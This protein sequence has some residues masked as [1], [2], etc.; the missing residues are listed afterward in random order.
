MERTYLNDAVLISILSNS[1]NDKGSE[2]TFLTGKVINDQTNKFRVG[3]FLITTELELCSKNVFLTKT[4][5]LFETSNFPSMTEMF[6]AEFLLMRIN[7]F[8]LEQILA[9]RRCTDNAKLISAFDNKKPTI[10][11]LGVELLG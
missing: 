5:E 6:C 3:K 11:P 8:E 1:N 7:S 2:V 9:M 4:G 10:E